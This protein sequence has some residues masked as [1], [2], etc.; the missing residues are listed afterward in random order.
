MA[1]VILLVAVALL[2]QHVFSL[3]IYSPNI[4]LNIASVYITIIAET[5][6]YLATALA[7]IS[8]VPPIEADVAAE[9]EAMRDELV[10]VITSSQRR[11]V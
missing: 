5:V 4:T 9:N 6:V 7:A 2:L 10:E 3:V 1:S 11:W 8:E